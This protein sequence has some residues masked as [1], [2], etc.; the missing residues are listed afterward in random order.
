[1]RALFDF[2]GMGAMVYK[3]ARH[4]WRE[5]MTLAIIIAMPLM[6]LAIYG[7]A[8]NLR[9]EHITTVY[10]SEDTGR[11][12]DRFV[13]AL[14]GSGAFD[15]VGRVDSP[16]A[17]R[18]AIVAGTAHVGFDIPQNFSADILRHKTSPVQVLVDGSQ[19]NIAQ[20]A[21]AAASQIGTAMALSLN[22][23][24]ASHQ[25]IDVRPLILF[26]PSLR[27]PNFLVPG[28]IGLVLQNITM[29]LMALSV[30]AERMR[31]TLDQVL[32][33]PIGTSALLLGK[34]IPYGIVGFLDFLLVLVMMVTIFQVPVAG[35]MPLLLVLGATFLMTSLGFGLLLSTFAQSQ[36]QALLLAAFF[37]VPST[38]LSGMFF[39][40]E[41]M[42]P[43]MQVVAYAMP[44]TYFL[45]VLR[46]IIV[47]G[48]TLSDLW[49][50][51]VATIGFG[52]LFLGLAS[53]RFARTSA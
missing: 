49:L 42:P 9:V 33:T 31:G 36:I 29:V 53:L 22:A 1:M 26:N 47:R 21:A 35:N 30:V 11:L 4:I 6:Q 38:L 51:T 41:L 43:A 16:E 13:S 12:A 32:V 45:E 52:L 39:Q 24:L 8:I 10:Y 19:S 15:V 20:A 23:H 37:I 14:Q 17:L 3:E 18:Q 28:L 44:L 34:I 27:S 50:P 7:Y 25:P 40:I 46:G 5:P 48:A 2:H